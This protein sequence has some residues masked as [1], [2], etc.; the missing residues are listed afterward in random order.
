MMHQHDPSHP[1]RNA[2]VRAIDEQRT[3]LAAR[4]AA[5]CGTSA[6]LARSLLTALGSALISME[7]QP[8]VGW[9]RMASGV[10]PSRIV[11]ST[12]EVAFNNALTISEGLAAE[13]IDL[14]SLL[15]FLEIVSGEVDLSLHLGGDGL[16]DAVSEAQSEPIE[17]VLAML[18]ARDEITCTHSRITGVWCRRIADALQ[19]DPV[20]ADLTVVGGLLHDLGKVATP[21]A[22]LL[23]PGPLNE[24][25]W[26]IM[27]AH[28]LAGA[29]LLLD[30]PSLARY[31][32]VV[33]AHHERIDGRGY[34]Y[35]LAGDEIPFEARIV[36]VADAFHA[37]TSDRPYRQ[38][39]SSGEAIE[40]LRTGRGKQWDAPVVDVM[41]AV[42]V[43][44]RN[45]ASDA[46]LDT[47]LGGPLFTIDRRLAM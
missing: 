24:D 43:E 6:M 34:P 40:I 36:A 42:A 47:S 45:E 21:D 28:S 5:Q 23:K 17:G 13:G 25:E 11:R 31:A 44:L 22:I 39:L 37:M 2:L 41:I 4:I 15:V 35:G 1:R 8:L 14:G 30:I 7:A 19:L 3:V 32:P 46:D 10:Y 12:I 29:D 18:K 38:A 20:A 26:E 16:P 9:A 33:R 27:R